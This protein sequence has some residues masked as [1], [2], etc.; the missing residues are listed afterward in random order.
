MNFHHISVMPQETVSGLV[1]NRD[2]IYVDCT[3]GGAGHSH[4]IADMLS[5]KGRLIG[6]DQDESA[7][8]AA[9]ERL[10]DCHCQVSIVQNNFRNLEQV[11]QEQ[12]AQQVDGVLF[13]LGVSSHQLDTAERGFSYMQDAPLDMRMD[14]QARLSAYDVVNSYDEAE[15]N[16]I[17]K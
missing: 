17:F 14:Q 12:S 10:Q 11:L 8:A 13:D 4:L 2:G 6:I 1:T 3:L 16:R 7:I 15:L 5:E 9:T